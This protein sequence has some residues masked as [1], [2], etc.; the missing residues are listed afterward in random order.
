MA[1]GLVFLCTFAAAVVVAV[2]FALFFFCFV[3]H[4]FFA[5]FLFFFIGV[6]VILADFSLLD[7]PNWT[8][9]N[10]RNRSNFTLLIGLPQILSIWTNRERLQFQ[11]RASCSALQASLLFCRPGQM[12]SSYQLTIFITDRPI[13]ERFV[14]KAASLVV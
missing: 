7:R 5:F 13:D 2:G 6:V 12:N 1:V 4:F 3:L 9:G 8:T 11:Y 14:G 10:G